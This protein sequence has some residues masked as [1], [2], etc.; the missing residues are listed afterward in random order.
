HQLTLGQNLQKTSRNWGDRARDVWRTKE[1]AAMAWLLA[2][3]RRLEASKY[4][5]PGV[6]ALLLFML[7]VVRGRSMIRYV[8]ARWSLR[9]RRTGNL[10]ASLAALEYTE[11]LRLLEQ[12]GWEKLPSQTALEFAAAIPTGDLSVPVAQLTELYQSARFGDHPARI[13]Q[14]SSIL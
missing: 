3:D 8:A 4:F 12:K 5:L 6:L 2:L 9:A 11:M 1:R 14:M 7:L 10:T 13:E